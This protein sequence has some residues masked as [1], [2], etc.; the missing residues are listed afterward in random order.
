MPN[1]STV[2]KA[3]IIRLARKELKT[4]LAHLRKQV[5][6]HRTALAS[7]KRQLAEVE[8]Q[9]KRQGR[10]TAQESA[11]TPAE[12]AALRF[13]A[14][15]LKTLRAKL[16]LSAADMGRLMGVSGQSVYNWEAEKARPQRAQLEALQGVRRI[17]KREA[18]A[19]LEALG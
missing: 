10:T 6:S 2:L 9:T 14:K 7:L 19:K 11:A 3:E 8:R 18:W 5:A 1:L 15:G 17:G 12:G 4:E 16:G 13:S